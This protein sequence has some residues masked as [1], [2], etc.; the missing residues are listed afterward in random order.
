MKEN[1]KTWGSNGH[2]NKSSHMQIG[3]ES[4]Q[5]RK[6]DTPIFIDVSR[7]SPPPKNIERNILGYVDCSKFSLLFLLIAQFNNKQNPHTQHI[8]Y[9]QQQ[10]K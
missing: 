9:K 3:G 4:I 6:L 7:T 1:G 10:P 5:G 8:H 2:Q